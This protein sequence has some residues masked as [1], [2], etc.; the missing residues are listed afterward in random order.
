M[1]QAIL[2][3]SVLSSQPDRTSVRF[4]VVDVDVARDASPD[5][6]IEL[7]PGLRRDVEG[8]LDGDFALRRQIAS[9]NFSPLLFVHGLDPLREDLHDP[10]LQIQ[11]G[12]VLQDPAA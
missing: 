3:P 7:A 5:D 8:A 1:L 2:W 4:L 10:L 9:L 6:L 12:Q 11:I